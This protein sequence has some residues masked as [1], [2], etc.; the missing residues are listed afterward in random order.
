MGKKGKQTAKTQQPGEAEKDL[1][2][3][4]FQLK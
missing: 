1:G 3:K 2:N 4:A